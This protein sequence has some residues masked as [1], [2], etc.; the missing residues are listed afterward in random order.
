[1]PVV[2]T[3]KGAIAYAR[4]PSV[5][6]LAMDQTAPIGFIVFPKFKAGIELGYEP[7]SRAAALTELMEHTFNVGLL[8]TSGFES[9]AHAIVN[10]KCYAVEYGDLPSIMEWVNEVCQ[11]TV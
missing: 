10:T 2:A 7:L 1:M 5:D 9:L 11:P 4:P 8:G 6:V 3:H